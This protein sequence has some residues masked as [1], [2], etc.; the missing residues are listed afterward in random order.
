MKVAG[1]A[2]RWALA[3]REREGTV[4]QWQKGMKAE[5]SVARAAIKAGLQRQGLTHHTKTRTLPLADPCTVLNFYIEMIAMAV[6]ISQFHC[7]SQEHHGVPED[8]ICSETARDWNFP[9]ETRAGTDFRVQF[10]K[11]L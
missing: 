7:K 11:C 6:K 4:R 3:E 5:E 10:P 2:D 9:M 8:K 1:M